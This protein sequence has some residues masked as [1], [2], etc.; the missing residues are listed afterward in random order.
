ML[1]GD[2]PYPTAALRSGR[3]GISFSPASMLFVPGGA[4][5]EQSI[6]KPR[7][8]VPGLRGWIEALAEQRQLGTTVRLS[9]AGRRAM[10]LTRL[11]GSRSAVAQDLL[12]LNDFLREFRAAGNSDAEAYPEGDGIRLTPAEGYLTLDA[13]KRTLPAMKTDDIR[14]RLNHLLRISVLR[15]GLIVTCGE[16]ERRAFYRIDTV[17]EK[18]PCPRCGAIAETTAAWRSDRGE[19]Q[20]FYDLHGAVRELLHQN[21]DVPFLAGMTLAASARNYEEVPELDF[22]DPGS[23][24]PDEIDIAAFKE[25]SVIIGEAKCIAS[26]GTNRES[27]RAIQKL[28]RVSDLVGANEIVLATTEPGPWAHKDTDQLLKAVASYEWR[29][30]IAPGIRVI[31]SLRDSPQSNVLA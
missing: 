17:S 13:A 7:L 10:I 30:G 11:W 8:R 5:L 20:W 23:E 12:D 21:G 19:P 15:R 18:N 16:C 6:A 2:E 22:R 9:Q 1:A 24:E 26:L 3:D 29:S 25:G 31:T 14:D 28:V 27:N 4:T